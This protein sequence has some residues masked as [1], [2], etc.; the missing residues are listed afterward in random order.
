MNNQIV[1]K[2]DSTFPLVQLELVVLMRVDQFESARLVGRVSD[3]L[4]ERGLQGLFG[5]ESVEG[6]PGQQSLCEGDG[7][8]REN[9]APRLRPPAS[10]S[11]VERPNGV[12]T[13]PHLSQ[14]SGLLRVHRGDLF[15]EAGRR[16]SVEVE[17]RL[18]NLCY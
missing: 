12:P 8:R 10:H 11:P 9:V 1:N 16:T 13:D 6:R 4:Q 18:N 5:R 3:R 14:R 7:C 15:E 17:H 2:K